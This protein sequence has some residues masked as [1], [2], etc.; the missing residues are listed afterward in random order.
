MTLN[1]VNALGQFNKEKSRSRG[2]S[3]T[4]SSGDDLTL[5]CRQRQSDEP[6]VAVALRLD[7]GGAAARVLHALDGV[8]E[9]LAGRDLL[10]VDLEN[11]VANLEA[12]VGRHRVLVHVLHQQAVTIA[13]GHQG[14]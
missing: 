7:Q 12:L 14:Q 6:D 5:V 13:V 10:V 4:W 9:L 11:G 1:L 8:R 2:G 3:G